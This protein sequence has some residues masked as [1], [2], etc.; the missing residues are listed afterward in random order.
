MWEMWFIATT[1]P[2]GAGIFSPS[3]HSCLVVVISSG[4]MIATTV[5]Q[6]QPRF[7]WSLRTLTIWTIWTSLL[8]TG[9][10]AGREYRRGC[11]D[12]PVTTPRFTVLVP[13][14]DGHGA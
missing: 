10:R 2:P 9:D 5:V 6:A 12:P 8:P 3:I 4:L 1:Q 7:S 13:V 11:E 14:K